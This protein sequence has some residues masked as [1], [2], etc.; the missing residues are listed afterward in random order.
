MFG[1]RCRVSDFRSKLG[2]F[3]Q[4]R[5]GRKRKNISELGALGVL[6]RAKPVDWARI[7]RWAKQENFQKW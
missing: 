7:K 6:A 4:R 2:F 1:F 3:S 5:K